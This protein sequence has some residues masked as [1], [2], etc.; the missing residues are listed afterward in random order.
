MLHPGTFNW[1]VAAN[2]SPVRDLAC[3]LIALSREQGSTDWGLAGEILLGW[4]AAQDGYLQEGLERI[5]RGVEGLRARKLNVW[6]PAYLLLQAEI[7]CDAGQFDEALERL[8]LSI[9][10]RIVCGSL[11]LP[12]NTS[13]A[14]GVPSG[15]HSNPYTIC[16]RSGR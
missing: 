10:S 14:T 5:R 12:S 9:C 2:L 6:L 16:G 7:C 4:Q 8:S 1:L 3:D 11:V 15:A 13:T